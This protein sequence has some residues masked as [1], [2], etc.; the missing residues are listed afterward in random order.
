ML[1]YPDAALADADHAVR[2]AREIG[3]AAT[4]MFALSNTCITHIWCKNYPTANAQV[5]EVIALADEKGA[6]LWKA[7]GNAQPRLLVGSLL[8]K[9]RRQSI[10]LLLE[11]LLAVNGF[12]TSTIVV[13]ISI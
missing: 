5:A 3:Q 4:L 11:A 2:D 7:A 13:S 9:L 10:R 6:V 8:T 1:G 12:N